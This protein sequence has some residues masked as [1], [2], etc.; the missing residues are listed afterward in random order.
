[1]TSILG[2]FRRTPSA[3]KAQAPSVVALPPPEVAP[4]P[5][6]PAP[7]LPAAS[8]LEAPLAL[9]CAGRHVLLAW[10]D[11]TEV[12]ALLLAGAEAGAASIHA[13]SPERPEDTD[14]LLARAAIRRGTPELAGEI[15]ARSAAALDPTAP[16]KDA[17]TNARRPWWMRGKLEVADIR[18]RLGPVDLVCTGES[19]ARLDGDPIRRLAALRGTG[20]TRLLLRTETVVADEAL[21]EAGF[22]EDTLWHAGELDPARAAA[23]DEALTRQGVALDQFRAVPGRLTRETAR[24]ASLAHPVWWFMGP[25]ALGRL[26][27]DAGWRMTSHR[28]EAGWT[29]AAASA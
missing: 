23:L 15:L 1:M 24:A 28:E 10:D 3:P 13:F 18:E 22:G 12:P 5:P 19:L 26:L 16:P 11:A 8:P 17:H 4:G 14:G 21:A 9:A 29:L 25:G 7:D 20:A 27:A 2:L 6:P